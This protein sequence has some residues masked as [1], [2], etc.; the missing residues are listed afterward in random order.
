M[1]SLLPMKSFCSFKT[2]FKLNL[3]WNYRKLKNKT[4]KSIQILVQ[5]DKS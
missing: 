4:V 3:N 2:H 5:N 1:S